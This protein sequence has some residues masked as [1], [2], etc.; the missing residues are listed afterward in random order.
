[1]IDNLRSKSS[2]IFANV[3]TQAECKGELLGPPIEAP[4][5]PSPED[6]FH[7]FRSQRGGSIV[8]WRTLIVGQ[9]HPGTSNGA[10]PSPHAD[11]HR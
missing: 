8:S 6:Y 11:S 9:D 10:E 7:I 1:M 2:G 4:S 3:A 5:V